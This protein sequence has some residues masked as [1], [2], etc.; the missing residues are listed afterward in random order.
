[1]KRR[2]IYGAF[3]WWDDAVAQANLMVKLNGQRYRVELLR[4]GR[5]GVT[6][7][8]PRAAVR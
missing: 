5:W 3:S 7:P 4:S 2:V 1:M 6:D 8:Y